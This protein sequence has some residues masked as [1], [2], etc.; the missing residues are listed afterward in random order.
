ML[1]QNYFHLTVRYIN[2]NK[3]RIR[4]TLIKFTIKENL[5]LESYPMGSV[6]AFR[7]NQLN[8]KNLFV[9]HYVGSR[10]CQNH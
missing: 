8:Q 10:G 1:G 7:R 5:H 3:S 9:E 2:L 4:A 6:D